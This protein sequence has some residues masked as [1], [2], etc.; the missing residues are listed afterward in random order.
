MRLIFLVVALAAAAPAPARAALRLPLFDASAEPPSARLEVPAL[1]LRATPAL[2]VARDDGGGA[3]ARRRGGHDP[4]VSLVLGIV[5]GFG[6]GH[7]LAGSGD[8]PIWLAVD[9]TLLLVL[10]VADGAAETLIFVLTVAERVLEGIDA[11]RQAQGQRG[12]FAS[13]DAAPARLAAVPT[14]ARN[15]AATAPH[16]WRF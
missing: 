6:I 9:A 5:P 12:L 16:G 2:A 13:H 15:L 4:V 1:R 14:G 7:V 8:W 10:V 3:P 11:Y